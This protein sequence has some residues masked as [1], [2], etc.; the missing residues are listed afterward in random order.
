MEL[1][2][3]AKCLI[4]FSPETSI[5]LSRLPL[6]ISRTPSAKIFSCF[7]MASAT[8]LPTKGAKNNAAINV[9][10]ITIIINL[11]DESISSINATVLSSITFLLLSAV[12]VTS[13]SSKTMP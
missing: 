3:I 8:L 13:S 1:K 7:V 2:Q 4:S 6:A 12:T 5:R 10:A 11:I 9:K